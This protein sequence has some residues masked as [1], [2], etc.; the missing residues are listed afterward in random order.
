MHRILECGLINLI[1]ELQ[2]SKEMDLFTATENTSTKVND[3]TSQ[4][5]NGN[6]RNS[7][8]N[9]R[10]S[11]SPL[12][13]YGWLIYALQNRDKEALEF[14]LANKQDCPH[15]E[16]K[17]EFIEQFIG[18]C[19]KLERKQPIYLEVLCGV[20]LQRNTEYWLWC[21]VGVTV[22]TIAD[23]KTLWNFA[24]A[25]RFDALK[26]I[27]LRKT[28]YFCPF[29]MREGNKISITYKSLIP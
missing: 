9:Y 28:Q 14:L 27:T 6:V 23:N 26:K 13:L 4:A 8:P 2:E 29:T 20:N 7:F 22:K 25:Y 10:K 15:W 3:I 19:D 16:T 17:Y 21:S 5:A 18:C 24:L 12:R 1:I 11:T